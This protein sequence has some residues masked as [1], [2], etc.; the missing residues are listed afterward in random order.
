MLATSS[1]WFEGRWNDRLCVDISAELAQII[2]ES[3]AV[4]S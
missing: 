1:S 4:S 2:E 3:W